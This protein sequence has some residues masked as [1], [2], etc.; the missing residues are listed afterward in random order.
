MNYER[1]KKGVISL[2]LMLVFALP[3][4]ATFET[5]ALAQGRHLGWYKQQE[6]AELR[7]LR[8]LER[9]RQLRYRYQGNYRRGGHYDRFGRFHSR[10]YYDRFGRFHPH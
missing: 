6:R 2:L 4:A 9:E 3:L 1:L 5:P 7:R 8:R 10:G